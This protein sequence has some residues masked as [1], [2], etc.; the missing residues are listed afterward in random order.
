MLH[1]R[2]IVLGQN[3]ASLLATSTRRLTSFLIFLLYRSLNSLSRCPFYFTA[4]QHS[5]GYFVIA[6][7]SCGRY[8]GVLQIQPILGRRYI[9]S[10]RRHASRSEFANTMF[11]P[12]I[13]ILSRI[14]SQVDV[15]HCGIHALWSYVSHVVVRGVILVDDYRIGQVFTIWILILA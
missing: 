2:R 12:F 5:P 10:Y 8:H 4:F 6:Y 9:V 3:I 13:F 1:K 14:L 15:D 7:A 11:S